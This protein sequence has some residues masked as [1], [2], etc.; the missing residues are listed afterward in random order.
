MCV[1]MGSI[2]NDKTIWITARYIKL[3]TTLKNNEIKLINMLIEKYGAVRFDYNNDE[4]SITVHRDH[5]SS[6]EFV[7][8]EEE[9]GFPIEL[10]SIYLKGNDL[11][12]REQV[13][14][15]NN[16]SFKKFYK[17]IEYPYNLLRMIKDSNFKYR[18]LKAMM[19]DTIEDGNI[20]YR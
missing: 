13:R 18:L 10:E 8:E 17:T 16:K 2:L 12:V 9:Y 15:K 5:K 1:K 11:F 14:I 6:I 4:I 19:E 20:V 3:N 7:Y